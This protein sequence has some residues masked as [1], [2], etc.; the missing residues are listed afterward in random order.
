V[1]IQ[2]DDF[3]FDGDARQLHRGRGEVH[4]SPKALDLLRVLVDERPRAL[5]KA[6]L[7][8]RLWPDTFVSDANLASLVKEIRD[9]LRDDARQPRYIRT[10]QRF[11]YA[12]CGAAAAPSEPLATAPAVPDG[13]G[14]C[15]LIKDG[16]RVPLENGETILGRDVEDGVRIESPTVSRRH[17][18]I[19][20][21]ADGA[22]IEDLKSKNGTFVG[23]EPVRAKAALRDRDEI[24][25]GSVVLRFRMA[26]RS[27]T[28]TWSGPS[29]PRG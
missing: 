21:T 2:F 26:S 28:A 24:R 23:D 19:L 18:R 20:I 27:R 13:A 4:L 22:T 17:A 3:L 12:F 1:K 29:R 8:E 10:A 25:V 6:E 9:A 15:W 14:L 7:H 16:T 5:S 11:G